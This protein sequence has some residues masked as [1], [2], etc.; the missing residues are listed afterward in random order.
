MSP[1][2][3]KTLHLQA[4]R[5]SKTRALPEEGITI[6]PGD[7]G[8]YIVITD[9]RRGFERGSVACGA[10]GFSSIDEVVDWLRTAAYR[11]EDEVLKK[12]SENAS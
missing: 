12:A 6:L 9:P 3:N 11:Y 10:T 2:A 8:G 4:L 7:Q 1:E 5:L